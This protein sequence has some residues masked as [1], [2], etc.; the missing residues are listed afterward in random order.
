MRILYGICGDGMGHAVRSAVVTSHLIA[1]GHEVRPVVS[2]DSAASYFQRATGLP[3]ETVLAPSAHFEKN[4]VDVLGT[5]AK[6]V[7]HLGAGI[8][9][10]APAF[11]RSVAQPPD[12]VISDFD[13][14]SAYV[15]HRLRVPMISLDNVHFL[16]RCEHDPRVFLLKDNKARAMMQ[17]ITDRIIPGAQAYMVTTFARPLSVRPGTSLHLPILRPSVL[18]LREEKPEAGDHLVSYLNAKA[19]HADVLNAYVQADVPVHHYGMHV[20]EP[21]TFGK[22]TIYPFSDEAFLSDLASAR[23]A[24]GG[25]GFTFMTEAFWLGKPVLAVPFGG[26]FEQI[27]NAQYAELLGWGQRADELTSERVASFWEEAPD[28]AKRLEDLPH[29]SNRELLSALDRE[30]QRAQ[31]ATGTPDRSPSRW[32]ERA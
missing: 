27:L 30:L 22:V 13:A 10:N 5:I 31:D 21:T 25:A 7:M 19:S 18:A 9:G 4:R 23:G 32:L 17:A 3:C 12:V 24:V 1:A 29:D 26:Q 8:V 16:S 14:W 28:Y 11:V 20:A 2:S 6:N 15:A